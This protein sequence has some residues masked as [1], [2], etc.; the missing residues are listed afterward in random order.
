MSEDN[1]N[2][3]VRADL[4]QTPLNLFSGLFRQAARRVGD[5][6]TKLPTAAGEDDI[7]AE[8]SKNAGPPVSDMQTLLSQ[9]GQVLGDT[10]T[11]LGFSKTLF[12]NA[13]DDALSNVHG[14]QVP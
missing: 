5:I 13:A 10:G 9:G 1:N 11:N 8:F 3:T 2:L 14:F 7:G 6:L 4:S 12:D